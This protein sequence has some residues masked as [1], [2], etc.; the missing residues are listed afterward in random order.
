MLGITRIVAFDDES[1]DL[2]ALVRGINSVG[3]TCLGVNFTGNIVTLKVPPC[4]YVRLVFV[5]LN[6]LGGLLNHKQNFGIIEQLIKK[7]E[8]SGPYLLVLWTEND[9]QVVQLQQ[10]LDE[11]DIGVAKPFKVSTLDKKCHM[12]MDGNFTDPDG[13]VQAIKDLI[14]DTRALAALS[15]W[16]ERVFSAAAET[17]SSVTMLG[18]NSKTSTEQQDDTP[19]LL[20]KMAMESVGKE[21]VA[22][23]RFRAVNEALLPILSDHIAALRTQDDSNSVWSKPFSVN[24]SKVSIKENEAAQ[25][26]WTF[27]I[28]Q[29]ISADQGAERGAVI[30]LP[31]E[32]RGGKFEVTFG[33]DESLAAKNQFRYKNNETDNEQLRWV[34]VQAQAACDYAQRQPGPL[35]FYLGIEIEASKSDSNTAPASLWRSPNFMMDDKI[36]QLQVNFRFMVCLPVQAAE[37]IEPLYRLREPLLADLIYRAHTYGA[38]PGMISFDVKN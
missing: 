14:E 2:N 27:H 29:D 12:D 9:P 19:R 13:L 7:L 24:A 4:P 5:D 1:K 22:G 25:L 35:P 26:N 8:P 33:M 16:E 10:F 37:N 36:Q 32:L 34:L 28:A 11:R 20:D 23:I 18:K 3:A 31:C 30:P 21:N 6:L 38:R 17:L 15:D